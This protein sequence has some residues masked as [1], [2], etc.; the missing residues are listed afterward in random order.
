M[1][2]STTELAF[3]RQ[4]A[5][6]DCRTDGRQRLEIRPISVKRGTS[7]YAN[8]SATA[9]I[10]FVGTAG[11]R[12]G[13]TTVVTAAVTC[14]VAEA[15]GPE[16][17]G[18]PRLGDIRFNVD[19]EQF[20]APSA[21][22]EGGAVSGAGNFQRREM[23]QALTRALVAAYGVPEADQSSPEEIASRYTPVAAPSRRTPAQLLEQ[24]R[25]KAPGA[26]IDL[27]SLYISH[28]HAFVLVVDVQVRSA[29]A[30]N[31][32]GAALA[33]IRSA[34][35]DTL[36]PTPTV[37]VNDGVAAVHLN[38]KQRTRRVISNR[39]PLAVSVSMD[40]SA[41]V[42]VADPAPAEERA[43][44]FVGHV[45]VA[46]DT[47]GAAPSDTAR[48]H[49]IVW[50]AFS[51]TRQPE[52]EAADDGSAVVR[53]ANGVGCGVSAMELCALLGEASGAL[54]NEIATS[55]V[56]DAAPEDEMLTA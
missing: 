32:F 50:S 36:L 28:A 27:A 21:A 39:C 19:I 29:S 44:P 22:I 48:H 24:A 7:A 23:E 26:P 47:S 41:G 12:S 17:D 40:P 38:S 43:F 56:D 35:A 14:D 30:G 20:G 11:S 46:A 1:S 51:G 34:L 2:L 9:S 25:S 6:H 18:E 37:T 8:G 15:T 54:F 53:R 42:Y 16:V 55:I 49:Q 4:G 31:V 33:A 52:P 10:G 5:L 45:A 13:E 3:A